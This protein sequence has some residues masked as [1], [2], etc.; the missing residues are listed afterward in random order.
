[1]GSQV[2]A[3]LKGKRVMILP[4]YQQGTWADQVVVPVRNSVRVSDE[5]DPLQWR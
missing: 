5:A 4:S 1:M 2:D 3:T